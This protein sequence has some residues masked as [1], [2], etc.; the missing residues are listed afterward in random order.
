M[1]PEKALTIHGMPLG[2][3]N[4]ETIWDI[5]G[6]ESSKRSGQED[7]FGYF[8]DLLKK[9][10]YGAFG[11]EEEP[12]GFFGYTG[13]DIEDLEQAKGTVP[14]EDIVK[15]L[16]SD[17]SWLDMDKGELMDYVEG[18]ELGGEGPWGQG[19]GFFKGT[20]DIIQALQ[21]AFKAIPTSEGFGLERKLGDIE[22][23]GERKLKSAR[24]GYIPGEILSRYG[25]L[26]GKEGAKEKGEQLEQAFT[27]DVYG[28]QRGVGRN[29]RS[30][31]E[32]YEDEWFSGVES[33]LSNLG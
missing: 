24:E 6:A 11:D 13:G 9:S 23:T 30:T 16:G 31:Y 14:E 19:G 27:S 32:D 28:V 12:F 5:L 10:E 22:E 29:I 8:Y 21:E 15:F 25:A 18:A 20:Y 4:I 7:M 1:I 17:M 3:S 26:Q 2:D 33:W